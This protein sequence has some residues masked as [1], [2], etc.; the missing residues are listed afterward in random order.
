MVDVPR[1][2]DDAAA[3]AVSAADVVLLV[4]PADVRSVAAAA[5]P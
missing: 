2:L 1:S 3:V 4:V 5:R